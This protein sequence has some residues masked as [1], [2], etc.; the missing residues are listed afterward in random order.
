MDRTLFWVWGG[1]FRGGQTN[2]VWIPKCGLWFSKIVAG[3]GP[4]RGSSVDGVAVDLLPLCEW[5]H[6]GFHT[7]AWYKPSP[8]PCSWLA[9]LWMGEGGAFQ[10]H[11]D[12]GRWS[13]LTGP[14]ILGPAP[15]LMSEQTWV[16]SWWRT[17]GER[18]AHLD[19]C[20]WHITKFSPGCCFGTRGLNYSVVSP[21]LQR[22]WKVTFNVP[23]AWHMSPHKFLTAHLWRTNKDT[24]ACAGVGSATLIAPVLCLQGSTTLVFICGYWLAVRSG[25]GRS[26]PPPSWGVQGAPRLQSRP[27]PP[28]RRNGGGRGQS[29]VW[30]GGR[31]GSHGAVC[32]W[33]ACE[34][35]SLGGMSCPRN[36]SITGLHAHAS[37]LEN[38]YVPSHF[39][40]RW[41]KLP[42]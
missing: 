30:W 24:A 27:W 19:L 25:P 39:W 6:E 36:H 23:G 7:G 28:R 8:H 12:K 35:S 40:G 16:P 18:G 2:A 32:P 21:C 42:S 17:C 38:C 15:H 37:S 41:F 1:L 31:H 4:W 9:E 13:L 20:A 34:V 5:A 29:S 33:R 10:P 22:V 26:M 11:T 3:V 14:W